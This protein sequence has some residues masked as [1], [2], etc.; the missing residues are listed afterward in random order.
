[1]MQ[2]GP[3]SSAPEE[4][5]EAGASRE[6]GHMSIPVRRFVKAGFLVGSGLLAGLVLSVQLDFQGAVATDNEVSADTRT[7][8]VPTDLESPFVAVAERVVPGVVAISTRGSSEGGDQRTFHPWGDM[9]EDL[10]PNNPRQDRPAPR[11]RRPEGSGSGFFMDRE[12]YILTNNH[13]IARAEEVLVTLSDGSELRAEVIGQDPATDVAVVK[14]DPADHDGALPT[15]GFGDSEE[16][17][18]GDWAIAIGNPFGQ[19]AGTLTVGVVSAKGRSDLNIMG[20]SPAYQNFI[21]TDAS[22]NF[23]NSGGPLVNIRGEVVGMNTAINAAGQGIGFAIPINL[24]R[25]IADDL[26]DNGK[27]VRGYLGIFPQ[28]LTPELAESMDVPGTKGVLIGD[29]L[30]DTPAEKGGLHT[31]DIITK[32]NGDS[33][34]D[35]NEFRMHVADQRVGEEIRLEIFRDGKK[36]RLDIVL[37]ERPDTIVASSGGGREENWSGLTVENLDSPRAQRHSDIGETEGVLVVDVEPDSPA[38]A[39]GIRP[40]DIIK[41]I[42]NLEIADTSDYTGAV[43]KYE[44]K[45][46]VAILLK[47]GTQTLYVGVRP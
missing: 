9:F 32:L 20:G 29:V 28:E 47:R 10:F 15:L 42:G 37:E 40:G 16:I 6:E 17:R 8:V 18:V 43:K 46:A 14:V 5:R 12:G 21:Q 33:V 38:D 27:V 1:M 36:K 45:K 26:I 41:E 24:A 22:I 25:R 4:P 13:V 30:A 7:A 2:R 31:G 19:L 34:S 39:A 3:G 11:R 44:E 23:G 35:V